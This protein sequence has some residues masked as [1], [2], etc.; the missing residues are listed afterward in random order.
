PR[1]IR[2]APPGARRNSC[3]RPLTL[4]NSTEKRRSL[5]EES[6]RSSDDVRGELVFD[7]GDAVAQEQLALFQP[8]DL[9]RI[10]SDRVLQRADRRI[11]SAMLLL[12]AHERGAQFAFFLFGHRRSAAGLRAFRQGQ[13]SRPVPGTLCRRKAIKSG[14]S[15]AGTVLWAGKPAA[16]AGLV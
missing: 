5:T 4:R 11:E 6:P 9:E 14:T 15:G 16:F 2:T 10:R 8:L 13:P 3:K 12:P 1:I 7:E